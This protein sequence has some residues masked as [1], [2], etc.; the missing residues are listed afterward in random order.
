MVY[1]GLKGNWTAWAKC[2]EGKYIVGA[3]L[4]ILADKGKLGDDSGMNGLKIYCAGLC[5]V[6]EA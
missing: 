3:S 1:S 5:E 4:R 2:P 6:G